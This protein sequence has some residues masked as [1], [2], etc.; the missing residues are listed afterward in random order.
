MNT[1][2]T[3]GNPGTTG[4]PGNPGTT[5]TTGTPQNQSGLVSRRT[6]AGSQRN[7]NT[8]RAVEQIKNYIRDNN[9]ETDDVLPTENQL[10][11]LLG[12][13]RSTIREA[14][15]ILETLDI[16][17]VRHGYGTRVAGMS[18]A[19][20][21][22]GLV[23]RI[24][25]SAKQSKTKLI[26]V[27]DT[28]QAL[29]MSLGQQLIDNQSEEALSAMRAAVDEMKARGEKGQNF[30]EADLAF[31]QALLIQINNPLVTELIEALWFVHMEVVPMMQMDL[32][33]APQMED[34]IHA[35]EDIINAI[36]TGDVNAYRE[37]VRRHYRP[38]RE[39]LAPND[40]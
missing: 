10:V 3:A 24:T 40:D 18:L 11:D 15:R 20:L 4:N 35:H 28:R 9:L 29:D 39:M 36:T 8:L 31:H 5:G 34:T 38:L 13:S 37:A 21:I 27:V 33:T 7:S 2:T 30:A 14:I 1:P 22:E 19:P 17:E 32:A 26:N 16:V 6:Q 25:Q 12:F 23:F